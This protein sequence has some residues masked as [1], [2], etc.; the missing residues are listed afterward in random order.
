MPRRLGTSQLVRAASR[1]WVACPGAAGPDL[2]AV[3]HPFLA[4]TVGAGLQPGQV[5]PGA[6]LAVEQAGAVLAGEQPAQHRAAQLGRLGE[7]LDGVGGDGT[8]AGVG[9]R[10]ARPRRIPRRRPAR[11]LRAGPGRR[12]PGARRAG[13]TR[14]RPPRSR[15]CAAV[16][17]R[18]PVLRQPCLDLGADLRASRAR[19][20]VSFRSHGDVFPQSPIS[21]ARISR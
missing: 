21:L 6:R 19:H 1:P 14:R 20:M 15:N 4:V 3:D 5:G 2:L 16:L 11:V 9:H 8:G 17:P 10:G 7:V 13:P 18:R 12:G